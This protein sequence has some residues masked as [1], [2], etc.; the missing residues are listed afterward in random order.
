MYRYQKMIENFSNFIEFESYMMT[1]SCMKRITFKK[2]ANQIEYIVEIRENAFESPVIYRQ[3]EDKGLL[4][5]SLEQIDEPDI[6]ELCEN[7]ERVIKESNRDY[8]CILP[9]AKY[10]IGEYSLN[11]SNLFESYE[12][13]KKID[14]YPEELRVWVEI[15]KKNEEICEVEYVINNTVKNKAYPFWSMNNYFVKY[16]SKEKS[17]EFEDII[18]EQGVFFIEALNKPNRLHH[19]FLDLKMPKEKE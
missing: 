13:Y 8:I 15:S 12:N 9:N 3:K 5:V 7:I 16:K 1:S 18:L 2:S 19:L 6:Q 17:F 14:R 11:V 4:L 10:E